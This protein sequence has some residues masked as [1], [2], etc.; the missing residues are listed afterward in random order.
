MIV[1]AIII[2]KIIVVAAVENGNVITSEIASRS[3]IVILI[4]FV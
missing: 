4:A 2:H 1:V 3:K